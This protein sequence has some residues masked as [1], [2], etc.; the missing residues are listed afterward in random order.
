MKQNVYFVSGID[1][2]AGKSYATGFLAREWNKN[3]QRTITQ[4]FIQT[5]NVGH[6]GSLYSAQGH[7][8]SGVNGKRRV[9]R[10]EYQCFQFRTSD[11]VCCRLF[12]A[13][14]NPY[15]CSTRGWR[16]SVQAFV[17]WAKRSS[18]CMR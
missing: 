15:D 14:Q 5:G 8:L 13:D 3:G 4:K 10:L 17:I 18:C 1:T 7:Q 9:F 2:D 6:S 12:D 11:T 16:L